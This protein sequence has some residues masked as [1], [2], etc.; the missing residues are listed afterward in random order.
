MNRLSIA[1]A[2]ACLVLTA[3]ACSSD[4]EPA[5]VPSSGGADDLAAASGPFAEAV[6]ELRDLPEVDPTS[7]DP[8]VPPADVD[9]TVFLANSQWA[10]D[11]AVDAHDERWWDSPPNGDVLPQHLAAGVPPAM[12]N[13]IAGFEQFDSD[14]P[15]TQE[16]VDHFAADTQPTGPMRIVSARWAA[17]P[18]EFATMARLETVA[19]VDLG[20]ADAARP[21]VIVRSAA[22]GTTELFGGL[23]SYSWGFTT[24]VYGHDPCVLARDGVITPAEDPD[25]D[26]TLVTALIERLTSTEE[27]EPREVDNRPLE[28]SVAEACGSSS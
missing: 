7:V 19:V 23:G 22:I 27:L 12:Q 2:V 9:P 28:E 3:A 11:L 1:V 26:V 16:F 24:D 25:G 14:L 10:L 18:T 6:A 4:D 13:Y 15:Y 20:G 17:E 5:G 8:P 21:V